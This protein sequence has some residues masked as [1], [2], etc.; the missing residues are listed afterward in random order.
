MDEPKDDTRFDLFSHDAELVQEWK[1]KSP[2]EQQ[3][4]TC[5]NI[6]GMSKSLRKGTAMMENHEKRITTLEKCRSKI[7]TIFWTLTKVAGAAVV[8]LGAGATI[9]GCFIK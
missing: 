2:E 3:E 5:L 6:I 8:I 9:Y 1:S 7:K 4:H